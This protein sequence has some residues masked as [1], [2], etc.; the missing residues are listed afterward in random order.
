M[1]VS[2]EFTRDPLTGEQYTGLCLDPADLCVAKL[3]AGRE[4]D[5]AFVDAVFRA[6]LVDRSTVR[7]RLQNM[8]PQHIK[9]AVA[10]LAEQ[11]RHTH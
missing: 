4:K 8:P 2:N 5:R 9:V 10:V 1:T 11:A 6:H 3:C 7:E